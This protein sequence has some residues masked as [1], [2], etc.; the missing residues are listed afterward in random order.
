MRTVSRSVLV[1]AITTVL[2]GLAHACSCYLI[3]PRPCQL[4]KDAGTVFVGKVISIENPPPESGTNA[5]ESGLARYHFSVDEAFK[6]VNATEIDV[7]SGRGGGDCSYHFKEGEIYIVYSSV[8]KDQSL[9]VSSCSDTRPAKDAA[10]LLQQLRNARDGLPVA[11]LFGT[12]R[13]VQS[14]SPGA[15][16]PGYDGPVPN[17][18]VRLMSANGRAFVAQTDE[19]GRYAFHNLAPGMYGFTA[20]ILPYTELPLVAGHFGVSGPHYNEPIKIP[21]G[22]PE[23][24]ELES[25]ACQ[26]HNLHDH[27][28]G[29]IRVRVV[30]PDGKPADGHLLLFVADQYSAAGGRATEAE[31][32]SEFQNLA[33]GEYI[34]VFNND[35][36]IRDDLFHRTFYPD[37]RDLSHAVRISLR[38]GQVADVTLQLRDPIILRPLIIKLAWQGEPPAK[39]PLFVTVRSNTPEYIVVERIEPGVFTADIRT[40]ASY[41]IQGESYC[42]PFMPVA[43]EPVVVEGDDSLKEIVLTLPKSLCGAR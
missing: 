39:M 22:Y 24:V 2:P 3:G 1:L 11:S 16:V 37:S 19:M 10:A 31:G 6:G 36:T 25:E 32:I 38:E 9:Q 17:I 7:Y 18:V 27:F 41:V 21:G 28:S 26:E 20:D 40:D 33:P 13:R 34:V 23:L 5:D 12:V 30:R 15:V 29:K 8:N 42:G 43:T 4:Q 14:K 35:D